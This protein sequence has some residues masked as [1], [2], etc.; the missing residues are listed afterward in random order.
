MAT[1]RDVAREAGVSIATVSRVFNQTALVSE[2]TATHVRGIAARLD[3]WP[4]SAARSLITHR[5]HAIGVLLP[6]LYGEFFSEVIRGID[7]AARA[8]KY[9][10]LVSS[11]HDSTETIV[12]AIRALRGRIDGLVVM[13]PDAEAHMAIEEFASRFPVVL[14]NPGASAPECGSIAITNYDGA[15][16]AVKHLAQLGHRRIGMVRG[17]QGNLDADERARGY[18]ESLRDAGLEWNPALEVAGDFSE[19]AGFRAAQDFLAASQRP[20]AVFCANDYMAIGLLSALRDEG[21]RVPQDMAI[22]GFD[23]IAIARYLTP[24]LT[25]VRVN[26]C[27]LGERALR[28][29]LPFARARRPADGQRE[30]LETSL[31]VRQSCGAP[32]V[33]EGPAVR[34]RRRS[35]AGHAH[36]R[37]E[38]LSSRGDSATA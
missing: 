17:P 14:L 37:D 16:A 35:P 29:L 2:A 30:E 21:V 34:A 36:H 8:E 24:T 5:T 9:Q 22:V 3:Y 20:S 7:L 11:F 1:I 26:A 18:R 4:N 33:S 31:V 27:E 25:T 32:S 23:D 38:R 12:S 13:V 10:V 28:Q 19:S 15:Y 6:D